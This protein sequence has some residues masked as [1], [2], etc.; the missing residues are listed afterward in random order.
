MVGVGLASS[1]VASVIEG[2]VLGHSLISAREFKDR[3]QV[4]LESTSV[5]LAS[6]QRQLT[7]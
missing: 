2:G 3:L 6:L 5:S 1:I 4:T 7:Y